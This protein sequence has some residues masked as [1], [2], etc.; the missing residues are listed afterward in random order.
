VRDPVAGLEAHRLLV[1]L[2][3]EF[4]LVGVA[5]AGLQVVDETVEKVQVGVARVELQCLVDR[6]AGLAQVE[7]GGAAVARA[8]ASVSAPLPGIARS[9]ATICSKVWRGGR[10][11][12]ASPGTGAMAAGLAGAA[13]LDTVLTTGR[14][15]GCVLNGAINGALIGAI[16]GVINGAL[17]DAFSSALGGAVYFSDDGAIRMPPRS[18]VASAAA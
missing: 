8:K 11:S 10:S 18:S 2:E 14:S 6:L 7:F 4:G 15:T 1:A 3:R 12:T 13:W 17:T 16:S 5:L 9:V